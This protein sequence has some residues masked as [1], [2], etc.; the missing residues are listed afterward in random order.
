M[1]IALHQPNYLPYLGFFDK[2]NK[3]DIFVLY[4]DAQFSKSDFHHRNKIRIYHG[5]RWLTVPV[6]KSRLP[7][8]NIK[9]RNDF[10]V[11]DNYWFEDHFQS[12][13]NNYEKSKYFHKYKES[14]QQIYS[15]EYDNLVDLSIALINMI[16]SGMFTKNRIVLSSEFDLKSTGT[17]KIIDIVSVLDGDVYLSGP[18]GH[19]YLDTQLFEKHNIRLEFQNFHHPVYSQCYDNFLP[20]MAAIDSLF[21]LGKLPLKGEI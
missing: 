3:S 8:K 9:I 17:Q 5:W 21:N 7:I 11:K 12:I 14:L 10:L 13:M 20:N 15:G 6:E 2:M 4:D 18:G 1:R 19:S 16:S